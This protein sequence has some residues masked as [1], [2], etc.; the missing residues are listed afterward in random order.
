[1]LM[2][3]M[4]AFMAS[5]AGAEVTTKRV[6]NHDMALRI[7]GDSG[8]W[9]IFESGLG[10][11]IDSWEQVAPVLAACA[12]TVVY[13]RLGVG[14]SSPRRG[15][16]AV[17]ASEVSD[18]LMSLLATIDAP[19]PYILVGHSLGGLYVQS[20]ARKHPTLV[21][22]VVLVDSASPFEPPGVFVST[23]PPAPGSIEAA[24]EAGVVPSIAAMLAGPPFPPVPLTV[25]VATNHGDTGE[26][27]ALWREVQARTAALSPK[28]RLEIV[29]E[30][31]HFIQSDRPQTV[32]GAVVQVA[33]AAGIAMPTCR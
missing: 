8:P 18:R 29:D 6:G 28:G 17:L 24:E 26:R 19:P 30:S 31:G 14:R 27:E 23:V 2:A 15:G 25:L 12:H 20:F 9:I 33:R 5:G 32:I 13:D 7:L 1:M 16:G 21:A 4:C 22:A 3:A 10:E 11:G